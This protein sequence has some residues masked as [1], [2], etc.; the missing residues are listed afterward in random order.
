MSSE[1]TQIVVGKTMQNVPRPATNRQQ[2]YGECGASGRGVRAAGML[3]EVYPEGGHKGRNKG[4]GIYKVENGGY[5]KL[6]F[7]NARSIL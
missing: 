3:T 5:I 4:S 1:R 2:I 6:V 7:I